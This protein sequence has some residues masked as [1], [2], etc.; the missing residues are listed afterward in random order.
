MTD[1]EQKIAQGIKA[2]FQQCWGMRYEPTEWEAIQIA[3]QILKAFN[4]E[5]TPAQTRTFFEACGVTKT[6]I[7]DEIVEAEG[8]VY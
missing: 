4:I 8:A 7:I 2:H 1:I 5:Q 3:L 6:G